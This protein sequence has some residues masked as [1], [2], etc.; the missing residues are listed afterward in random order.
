MKVIGR[1]AVAALAAA[2][3]VFGMS[4]QA[5]ADVI[6]AQHK[7]CLLTP[8]GW[9][10]IAEGV[11]EE[12]YLQQAPALDKFHADVHR[13]EPT[14]TGGLTIERI[15]ADEDCSALEVPSAE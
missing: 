9:V 3:L 5:G 11:S 7:H 2:G 1:I 4:G 6:V 14:I 15:D 10:L 8:N 13:G 12:A